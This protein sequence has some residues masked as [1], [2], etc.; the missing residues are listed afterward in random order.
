[1]RILCVLF[2]MLMMVGCGTKTTETE[3][4]EATAES[5]YSYT[6][7]FVTG[8]AS[9][10]AV[11]RNWNSAVVAKDVDQAFAYVADSLDV[12]FSDGKQ[13]AGTKAAML[14]S[15][16]LIINGMSSISVTNIAHVP[17]AGK[18]NGDQW[19]LAYSDES[20]T[21]EGTPSRVI[22]HEVYR[23]VN[24]K[25]RS[26]YQYSHV[27]VA[28][29]EPMVATGDNYGY[30][31]SFEVNNNDH[32]AIIEGFLDGLVSR[33]FDAASSYLADSVY[34]VFPDGNVMNTVKDSVMTM[35][36]Q[37]FG[38]NTIDIAYTAGVS[39]HSTDKNEDLVLLWTDET[40]VNPEGV[41]TE[42]SYHDVYQI[43][44]NKIRVIRI[45]AQQKTQE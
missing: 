6:N 11:L 45:F 19:V 39:V 41:K 15:V 31:G 28:T 14:D 7:E 8:D 37:Y 35:A 23:M 1:M 27:P 9:N 13:M 38:E 2:I 5:R 10:Q 30:S 20:Y 4:S 17:V 42:T 12:V 18:N 22:I 40:I 24:G 43:V 36:S 32:L 44:D 33:N 34:F 29:E 16:K 21:S 26:I 3:T 25:I